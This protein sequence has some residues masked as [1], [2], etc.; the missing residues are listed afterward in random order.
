MTG[1]QVVTM[2]TATYIMI[3]TGIQQEKWQKRTLITKIVVPL[4]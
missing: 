3:T 1:K 4:L 2:T